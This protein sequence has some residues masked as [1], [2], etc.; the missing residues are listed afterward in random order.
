M[1]SVDIALPSGDVRLCA[2]LEKKWTTSLL[3]SIM[4]PSVCCLEYHA[5]RLEGLSQLTSFVFCSYS[6]LSVN[7]S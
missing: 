1:I 7:T 3:D 5:P 2:A 4:C 6:S